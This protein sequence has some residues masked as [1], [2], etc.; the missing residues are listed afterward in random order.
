MT[1]LADSAF[2]LAIV[3]PPYGINVGKMTLG[4]NARN[5]RGLYKSVLWDDAIPG[6]AYFTEL[7]RVSKHQII[8]GGN[9]FLEYLT[10]TRCMVVWDKKKYGLSFADGEIAWTSFDRSTRIFSRTSS[11]QGDDKHKIMAVQ[12][13]VKL[14]E[15]LLLNFAEKGQTILDTHLGSGSSAIAAHNFGCDFVGCEIDADYYRAAVA[16]FDDATRQIPLFDT[17]PDVLRETSQTPE[18]LL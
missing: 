1:G 10:K 7:M 12:K 9:Y 5:S 3:D 15:W 16:R 11:A 6:R 14:Y 18:L 13:P 2:D 8:W 17:S 4:D